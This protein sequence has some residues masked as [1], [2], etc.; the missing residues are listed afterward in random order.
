MDTRKIA[1]FLAIAL[2]GV[3]FLSPEYRAFAS[4]PSYLALP[5]G[6]HIALQAVPG[7][8]WRTQGGVHEVSGPQSLEVS[9]RGSGKL[10]L[11]L[12]GVPMKQVAVHVAPRRM[13][14]LGGQA[15]GVVVRGRGT[16]VVGLDRIPTTEGAAAEPGKESGL[17]I[18]DRL[19]SVDGRLV[20]GDRDLAAF[21]DTAGR[22]HRSVRLQIERDGH[23]L[24]IEAHPAFD[25]TLGRYRLG[26]F[27]RDRMTGV[28]TLTF[29][30]PARGRF[31][32]LGHRVAL[33]RNGAAPAAG[34]ILPAAIVGVQRAVRGK[35]G[36]KIGVIGYEAQVMGRI[37]RNSEVGVGGA[38]LPR[39]L[40]GRNLPLATVSQVHPGDAT[41][42]TVLREG[43]VQGFRL[44]IERVVPDRRA[45]AKSLVLRITDRRLLRLTGGIVQG[46]SGSPIVQDGRVA[47][48]ITHVFI[49]DPTRG[50]GTFAAWMYQE[51]VSPPSH[52]SIVRHLLPWPEMDENAS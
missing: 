51:L 50:Y 8:G 29:S 5:A 44:R 42:Y 15:I 25:R 13:V 11:T 17:R 10:A 35:P 36:Q 26:V 37:E 3:G 6:D 2:L 7:F 34:V 14:T 30:D 4:L 46:M 32:A 40:K 33:T 52:R 27:V 47:G 45:G 39:H 41:L 43:G 18:G 20:S 19:V 21:V 12:G 9:A 22:L 48:A 31:A 28:G 38:L 23:K 24:Q 16:T 49:H 1:S